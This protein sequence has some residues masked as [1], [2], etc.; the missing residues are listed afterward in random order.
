MKYASR[1]LA[2]FFIQAVSLLSC[3]KKANTHIPAADAPDLM[4]ENAPKSASQTEIGTTENAEEGN[5]TAT[6]S[7]KPD[8]PDAPDTPDI[9]DVPEHPA[10]KS[11]SEID[12]EKRRVNPAREVWENFA[13]SPSL[14]HDMSSLY[15]VG[16]APD[17]M[18]AWLERTERDGVGEG[19][20]R[21]FIQ[22]LVTDEISWSVSETD[23]SGSAASFIKKNAT[24][25]DAKLSAY[26]IRIISDFSLE[27]FPYTADGTEFTVRVKM[28]ESGKML[29][30][31]V[32]LMNYDVLVSNGSGKEKIIRSEKESAASDV[33]ISGCI[34]SPYEKRLALI[35]SRTDF[36]FEGSDLMHSVSGCDME[37]GF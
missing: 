29:N 10:F 31:F 8:A 12:W 5:Q 35:V 16:F 15:L 19:L 37:K 22:D 27:S 21:F 11:V 25:I 4:E 23:E 7:T 30:D 13:S 14:V 18:S 2:V 17:G 33:F 34:K 28:V 3:D 26:G 32:P 9:L 36:G 24:K 6:V 20:F 1:L